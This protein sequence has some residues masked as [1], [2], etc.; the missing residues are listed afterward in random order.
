[1][2]ARVTVHWDQVR[3]LGREQ[4]ARRAVAELG[5]AVAELARRSAPREETERAYG[6][7]AD[8]ITSTDEL[9]PGGWRARVSWDQLHYYMRFQR[10]HAIQDAAYQ[11]GHRGPLGR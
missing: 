11:L 9:G 2:A 8:S 6:H 5:A 1:M 10:S 3:A 7:G 4:F